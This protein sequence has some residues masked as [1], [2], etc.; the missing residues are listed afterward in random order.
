MSNRLFLGRTGTK[1]AEAGTIGA[2][3]RAEPDPDSALHRHTPIPVDPN[4]VCHIHRCFLQV[5]ILVKVLAERNVVL[6]YVQLFFF[7]VISGST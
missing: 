1:Q 4:H 2:S 3:R 7:V 5:F 6:K